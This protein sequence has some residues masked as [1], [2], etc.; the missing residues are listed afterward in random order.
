MHVNLKFQLRTL[1]AK[2]QGLIIEVFC[3]AQIKHQIA[4]WNSDVSWCYSI[5][6]RR[7]KCTM[8][9]G[10]EQIPVKVA[11]WAVKIF[12]WMTR[13]SDWDGWKSKHSYSNCFKKQ[14]SNFHLLWSTKYG[15][16]IVMH[17]GIYLVPLWIPKRVHLNYFKS[18][19]P[20][21][22]NMKTLM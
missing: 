7:R 21:E 8:M 9:S 13:A 6:P 19:F 3:E 11:T 10:Y 20:L 2:S 1:I 15:H 16:Q 17:L 22:K 5:K 4:N 14:R 12:Q 18:L